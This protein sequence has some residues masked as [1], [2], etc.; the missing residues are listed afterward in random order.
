MIYHSQD[1]REFNLQDFSHLESRSEGKALSVM[2]TFTL[3]FVFPSYTLRFGVL[4][5]PGSGCCCSRIQSALSQ[6]PGRKSQTGKDK[7]D[8]IY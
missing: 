1:S 5:G 7:I 4:Q 3:K 8:C 6:A 2:S